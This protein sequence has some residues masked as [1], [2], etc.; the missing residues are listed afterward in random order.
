MPTRRKGLPTLPQRLFRNAI[1][2]LLQGETALSAF[3]TNLRGCN[4]LTV[5]ASRLKRKL[6]F[7]GSWLK[8]AVKVSLNIC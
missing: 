5:S 6:R 3:L 8:I 1:R 4:V 2:A 7:S